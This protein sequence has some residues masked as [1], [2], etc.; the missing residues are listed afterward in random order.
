MVVR[1][2]EST[3][4]TSK[5]DSKLLCTSLRVPAAMSPERHVASMMDVIYGRDAQAEVR[6][7]QAAH[8][9][10]RHPWSIDRSRP[11][12]P[13]HTGSSP[14]QLSSA[15]V[16]VFICWL[17]TLVAAAWQYLAQPARADAEDHKDDDLPLSS[18][19]CFVT[20]RPGSC[21]AAPFPP[22]LLASYVD[23]H[24]RCYDGLWRRSVSRQ[25]TICKQAKSVPPPNST[26]PHSPH[27]PP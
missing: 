11:H 7:A 23:S 10:C 26:H 12:Q 2:C 20:V 5:C 21:S 15:Q 24:E 25:R 19:S 13:L 14:P 8:R 3:S 22:P 9:A 16:A 17:A 27:H 1:V 4:R 6:H 18:V